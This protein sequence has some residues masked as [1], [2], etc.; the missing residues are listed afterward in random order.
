MKTII[1]TFA[2]GLALSAQ[3][4]F[5]GSRYDSNKIRFTARCSVEQCRSNDM[6]RRFIQY[7]EF[8]R[9][10]VLT[11]SVGVFE[12]FKDLTLIC[13]CPCYLDFEN[14]VAPTN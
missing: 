10:S 8:S 6:G 2:L 12:L 14:R 7:C 3:A 5:R 13:Y 9:N 1:L 4:T 11:E